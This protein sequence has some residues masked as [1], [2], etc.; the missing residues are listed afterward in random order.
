[1]DAAQERLG[2]DRGPLHGS[3]RTAP[4]PPGQVAEVIASEEP[5][6]EIVETVPISPGP[7]YFWIGGH[8][9]WNGGWVWVHGRFD[10]HPTSIRA[11]PGRPATGCAAADPGSG[12]RA[13]GTNPAGPQSSGA[14]PLLPRAMRRAAWP[15]ASARRPRLPGTL[16]E[17]EDDRGCGEKAEDQVEGKAAAN[18]DAPRHLRDAAGSS[19]KNAARIHPK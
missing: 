10:R 19:L 9:H 8:W 12:T 17:A 18:A 4:L 5:P 2:L 16:V 3:G 7:D 15:F 14:C 6:A 11:P 13:A 1:M